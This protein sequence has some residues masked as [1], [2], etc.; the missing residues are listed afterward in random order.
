M[1]ADLLELAQHREHRAPAAEPILVLLDPRQPAVDRGPVEACLLDG[2]MT[3]D[4]PGDEAW[5]VERDLVVVLRPPED[6]GLYHRPQPRE[7]ELVVTR[8]D[9]SRE[10]A[11]EAIV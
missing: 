7:P 6:E 4:P 2:E 1:V 11:V 9:R 5:K 3:L 8:L 10:H